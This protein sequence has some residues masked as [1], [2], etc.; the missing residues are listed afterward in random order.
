ML[1]RELSH[2]SQEIGFCHNDLQYGNIMMDEETRS[3]TM[4]VSF[5]EPLYYHYVSFTIYS[6][7][8]GPAVWLRQTHRH[9]YTCLLYTITN[10]I[11]AKAKYF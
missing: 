7:I 3:I 1:E 11:E 2:D 5:P 4:I 10:V 6:I 9:V 8:R